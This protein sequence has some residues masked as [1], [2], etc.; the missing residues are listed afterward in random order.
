MKVNLIGKPQIIMSNDDSPFNYFAWPTAARLQNGKIAVVTSG[1]RRRHVCPFGKTVISYSENDGET[2]TLPAVLFDTFVDN[3]D[4]GIATFGETGVIVTSYDANMKA[5]RAE[6]DDVKFFSYDDLDSAYID[7][8]TE[9]KDNEDTGSI[10]R[11][12]NDCG[13]TFSK[14]MKSPVFSPHG[15]CAL[16]DGSVIWVGCTKAQYP[17]AEKHSDNDIQVYSVNTETGEMAYL[18][19]I[20]DI[21]VDGKKHLACEP[22]AIELD[23]GTI[24]VHIR[25]Q[26]IVIP[27]EAPKKLTIFQSVSKDKG[28]TWSK[29]EQIIG[30]ADGAP[31]YIFKHSSGALICTYCLRKQ[32]PFSIRAMISFDNGKTWDKNHHLYETNASYDMGYPSTVEL[33]DGSLATIFYTHLEDEAFESNDVNIVMKGLNPAIIMQQKWSFEK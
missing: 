8:V 13:V 28:K 29:P 31:P 15:P 4:G 27:P 19:S 23:D 7:F 33:K 14:I 24:I 32:T 11:I 22:H 12:S 25:V 30:D 17:P 5:Q 21:Y 9:E 10:F 3:R 6:R 26:D 20:D 1:L 2:Y 16:K 18:S